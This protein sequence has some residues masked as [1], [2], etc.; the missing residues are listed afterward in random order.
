MTQKQMSQK[1]G[2]SK[3]PKKLKAVL[4]NLRK[5]LAARRRKKSST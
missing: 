5:A 2:R 3:S 4:A 1:G